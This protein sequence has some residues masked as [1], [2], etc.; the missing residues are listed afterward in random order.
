VSDQLIDTL[1][2]I[3]DASTVTAR[4]TELLASG[5]DELLLTQVPLGDAAVERTRLM[6]VVGRI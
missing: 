5:L 1:V 6:H 4:L 3:G 2:V